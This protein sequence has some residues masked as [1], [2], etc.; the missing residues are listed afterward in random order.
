MKRY[1]RMFARVF[2]VSTSVMLAYRSNVVFF[3][4]FETI[5]LISQFLTVSVG[6]SLAG[7]DIAGWTR[8]QAYLLTA[9]NGLS[10][11]FFIC[12]FIN[13]IFGLGMHV[14]SGQYDYV[15]LKP[16]HPLVSTFFTSGQFVVSN[17]PNLLINL[18][19]VIYLML[20]VIPWG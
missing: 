20:Y 8:E 11:Q 7:G 9:V 16:M 14:W 17:I 4:V 6:Y 10:H 19:V 13:S 18:G 1:L 3:L 2:D 12:F 5:F 15:L